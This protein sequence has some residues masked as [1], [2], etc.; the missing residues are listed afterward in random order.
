LIMSSEHTRYSTLED[1]ESLMGHTQP[2]VGTFDVEEVHGIGAKIYEKRSRFRLMLIFGGIAAVI[3]I[4]ALILILIT[5]KSSSSPTFNLPGVWSA[6]YSAT[7]LA[8]KNESTING[9]IWMDKPS[10]KLRID[11]AFAYSDMFIHASVILNKTNSLLI[12]VM[13]NMC[14]YN[15]TQL[16]ANLFDQPLNWTYNSTDKDSKCNWFTSKVAAPADDKELNGTDV[17][18]SY[19]LQAVNGTPVFLNIT[20]ADGGISICMHDVSLAPIKPATFGLPPGMNCTASQ[21]G[22]PGGGGEGD[23]GNEGQNIDDQKGMKRSFET[24]KRA[25]L[26]PL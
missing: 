10:Q 25:L 15:T 17:T 12:L 11:S 7:V 2:N 3:L 24:V 6:N 14:L 5:M 20:G 4:G 9:S 19:C 22:P 23:D 1:N 26:F 18:F 21:F 16:P 13:N 8:M